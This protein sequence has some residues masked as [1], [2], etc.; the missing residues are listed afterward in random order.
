MWS[1]ERKSDFFNVSKNQPDNFVRW[2]AIAKNYQHRNRF[3][4]SKLRHLMPRR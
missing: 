3:G 1:I 4:A 2:W